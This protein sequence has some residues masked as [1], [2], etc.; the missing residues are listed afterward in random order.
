[1]ETRGTKA[2]GKPKSI[3]ILMRLRSEAIWGRL[4]LGEYTVIE[5]KTGVPVAPLQR[6]ERD[7]FLNL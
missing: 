6:T 1:M 3:E 7:L 2:N 4:Q 5:S